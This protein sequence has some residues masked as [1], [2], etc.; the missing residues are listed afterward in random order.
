MNTSNK[1]RKLSAI[2]WSDAA[3]TTEPIPA[4]T[5]VEA[6]VS[7]YKFVAK[8]KASGNPTVNVKL[9]ITKD[10]ENGEWGGRVLFRNFS[11]QSTSL[12]A[13]KQF[14]D[15]AGAR[16]DLFNNDEASVTDIMSELIGLAVKVRIGV[17]EYPE[18]S[19]QMRNDVA[20]FI[21]NVSI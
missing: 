8:S 16:E 19:G 6:V 5:I 10:T 2:K 15:R 20:E 3:K 1:E 14:A 9:T 4:D 12:W 17:H 21:Q 7:E 13:L 18:G 11:L